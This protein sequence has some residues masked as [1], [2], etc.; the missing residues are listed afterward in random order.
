MNDTGHVLNFAA[1]AYDEAAK[2]KRT[3]CRGTYQ[4]EGGKSLSHLITI[5]GD[6]HPFAREGFE[7]HQRDH[8][9][10]MNYTIVDDEETV[11]KRGDS[12]I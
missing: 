6:V 7:K 11:R 2:I 3:L 12:F 8:Y 4:N 5:C 9:T 1:E 10:T